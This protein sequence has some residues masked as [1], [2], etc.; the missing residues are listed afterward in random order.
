MYVRLL[1]YTKFY[2]CF[3]D[4][5]NMYYTKFYS[6]FK[7]SPNM[8][9][10][11]FY[12]CFKDSP[13]LNFIPVSKILP[14]FLPVPHFPCQRTTFIFERKNENRTRIG[15][16]S[17]IARQPKGENKQKTCSALIFLTKKN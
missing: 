10:T 7:D 3:K 8:Y 16:N 15:N 2:S 9:Y 14:I 6:C 4:S 5:P 1:Y 11:K 17:I 13:K 12:S